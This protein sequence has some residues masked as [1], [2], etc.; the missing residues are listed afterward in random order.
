MK[1]MLVQK[2]PISSTYPEQW[3]EAKDQCTFALFEDDKYEEWLGVFGNGGITKYSSVINFPN[4]SSVLVVAKGKGYVV[5]LQTRDLRY[6]TT[7]DYIVQAIQIPERDLI[8]ACDFTKLYAFSSAK[9]LWQSD[10]VASDGIELDKASENDVRGKVWLYNHWQQFTL[11]VDS[12]T[13]ELGKVI[14]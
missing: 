7:I 13:M 2:R 1:A 3:Y 10:D 11:Y 5:D 8:I 4:T 12:L 6:Q 14:E 9:Q